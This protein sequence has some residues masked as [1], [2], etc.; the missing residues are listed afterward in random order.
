MISATVG[1]LRPKLSSP[2]LE[3]EKEKLGLKEELVGSW[4]EA[5]ED[6]SA[7]NFDQ[8]QFCFKSLTTKTR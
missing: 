8:F 4:L 1:L 6:G 5:I 7:G 2:S 3:S